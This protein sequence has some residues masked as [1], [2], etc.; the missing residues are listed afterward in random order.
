[1]KIG[2]KL[3]NYFSGELQVVYF[4]S[5]NDEYTMTCKSE[6]GGIIWRCPKSLYFASEKDA[7]ASYAKS[8]MAGIVRNEK[9]VKEAAENLAQ[10]KACLSKLNKRLKF[11]EL[12][13]SPAVKA[14]FEADGVKAST[15]VGSPFY[16]EVKRLHEDGPHPYDCK[17]ILHL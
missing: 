3:Y 9:A 14:N 15:E 7:I 12:L 1:M 8:L 4:V 5:D 16:E 10:L 11:L 17:C 13:E 2:D 6:N